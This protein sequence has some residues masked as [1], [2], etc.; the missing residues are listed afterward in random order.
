MLDTV[1]NRVTISGANNHL[2]ASIGTS[3]YPDSAKD[4]SS[5]LKQANIAMYKAKTTRGNRYYLK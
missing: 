2:S 4:G 5:L 3:L 1:K